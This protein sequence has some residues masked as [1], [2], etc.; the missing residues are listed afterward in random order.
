MHE[1]GDIYNAEQMILKTLQQMTSE[2]QDQQAKDAYQMHQQQTQQQIQNL[3][4]CFQLLGTQPQQ[5][6]CYAVQ[7]LKQEHD[8][9]LQEN[10]SPMLI[11]LFDLG[12]AEK[13]EHYEIAS[14]TGLIEKA[15]LMG[16]QQVAQ[17]LRQNLQQEQH[18]A[19]LVRQIGQ[20][21]GQMAIGGQM[22]QMSAQQSQP[23]V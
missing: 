2:S 20:Q 9:F 21:L 3:D 15:R 12:A 13:T 18:M 7:G 11:D 4:Q 16:Q 14:Y 5:V 10:P 1:L 8:H 23:T 6:T 22:G 17:L 19:Q